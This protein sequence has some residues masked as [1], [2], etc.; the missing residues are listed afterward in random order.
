MIE[1]GGGVDMN[2][3]DSSRGTAGLFYTYIDSTNDVVFTLDSNSGWKGVYDDSTP[4]YKEHRITLKL[5]WET[6]LSSTVS[7]LT[8]INTFYGFI[9]KDFAYGFVDTSGNYETDKAELEGSQWGITASIGGSFK[10]PSLTLEPYINA[11]YRDLDLDGDL[12][13]DYDFGPT[14]YGSGDIDEDRQE[15]FVGAGLS[16]LFGI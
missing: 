15:W 13:I 5:G 7:I 6:N 8:G 2:L 3:C 10:L 11:G 16:V 1:A 14:G 12:D 9:N 4:D